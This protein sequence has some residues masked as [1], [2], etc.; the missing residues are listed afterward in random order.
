VRVPGD[1]AGPKVVE[2][3]NRVAGTIVKNACKPGK[4]A[5]GNRPTDDDVTA[6]AP[7]ATQVG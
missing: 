3:Q 7:R 1:V 5:Q 4:L 6:G 2:S